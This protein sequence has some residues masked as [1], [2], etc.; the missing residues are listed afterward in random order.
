V[1]R[2]V[3]GLHAYGDEAATFRPWVERLG[4][5]IGAH[6]VTLAGGRR[7]GGG[8]AWTSYASDDPRE[9]ARARER[10]VRLLAPVRG[11]VI[12]FG[13]SQGAM[14]ALEVA[15]ASRLA[16]AAVVGVGAFL[17]PGGLARPRARVTGR[18]PPVLLLHGREDDAVPVAEAERV[19][20]RV[21]GLGSTAELRLFGGAGHEVTGRM[22]ATAVRFLG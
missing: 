9:V 6:L 7:A 16:V 1:R 2:V 18:R 19:I 14:L 8:R 13:F 20:D 11:R 17:A 12:L 4:R 21:R 3:V 10:V 15:F 22:I 5:R